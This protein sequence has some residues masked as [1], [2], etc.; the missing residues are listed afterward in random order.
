MQFIFDLAAGDGHVELAD[1]VFAYHTAEFAHGRGGL[2]KQDDARRVAVE[3][4]DRRRYKYLFIARVVG[5]G[6]YQVILH[7]I[8]KVI[9]FLM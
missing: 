9:L 8:C 1:V 6:L 5:A 4:V 3:P 2:A 7:L